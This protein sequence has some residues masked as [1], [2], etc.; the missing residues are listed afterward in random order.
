MSRSSSASE[1]AGAGQ[2]V[3]LV[4]DGTANYEEMTGGYELRVDR[5]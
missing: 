3:F 2:E 5:L 4:V 1:S